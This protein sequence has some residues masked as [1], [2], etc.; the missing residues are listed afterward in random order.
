MSWFFFSIENA[1]APNFGNKSNLIVAAIA[2][3]RYAAFERVSNDIKIVFN[4]QIIILLHF[5]LNFRSMNYKNLNVFFS[6]YDPFG[7]GELVVH[8]GN[9]MT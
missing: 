4:D 6:V 9:I 5:E 2:L 8:L 7:N 1:A 3:I